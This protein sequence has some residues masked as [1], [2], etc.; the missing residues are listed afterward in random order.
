MRLR[1]W[2]YG[3]ARLCSPV[4]DWR[5]A[6][7]P[8]IA[9]IGAWLS[10]AIVID[11]DTA[12]AATAAAGSPEQTL[13]S[14]G[15]KLTFD[16][17]E[18][19]IEGNTV[20][21][22]IAIER[23]VYPYLGP[24]RSAESVEDARRAL[25]RAYQT[26]GYLTV[27]VDVPE[28][29]VKDGVV[30]LRVTE[31]RVEQLRVSDNRYYSR[32]EIRAS[33]PG[34]APGVV[35]NFPQV[36]KQLAALSTSPDRKITPVLK[37]GTETGTVDVDLKVE[38]KLPLHGGVELNNRQSPN[39]TP[40]RF[41]ANLRYD[42]LWQ[43]GHGIGATVQT[44]PQEPSK[45]QVFAATYV[46]PVSENLTLV[47][48]GVYSNSDVAAI[49]GTDV[50][51]NGTIWGIR[52][53]MPLPAKDASSQSV[54]LGFD[55]KDFKDSV[56][57]EGADSIET[58]I[59][60]G[61][62]SAQYRATF[63][64]GTRKHDASV[65]LNF[66]PRG[67]FGNNDSEFDDKRF[68]ATASFAY[69]RGDWKTEQPLSAGFALLGRLQ[70]QVSSGPLISNE[71]FTAGG[72]D[73]VRGYLE[74]EELGDN[75]VVAGLELRGPRLLYAQA[76]QDF[77]PFA[78]VEGGVLHILQPLPGQTSKFSLSSAGLGLRLRAYGGF[79]AAIDVALPFENGPV[80]QAGHARVNFMVAYEF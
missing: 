62:L 18:Y 23:A 75:G 8:A 9:V 36:Q 13:S 79:N 45:L 14:T 80:T 77:F 78:F 41:V 67:V 64:E 42:N 63:P 38:D 35:P 73:S 61:L 57:V 33:V 4:T 58:P 20:L 39:T 3:V 68:Q 26:A 15:G 52:A 72:V 56:H 12:L 1:Q 55:Y 27:V 22:P 24:N 2:H 74:A 28:Q 31:G 16:I 65:S 21:P 54:S 47:G 30:R 19:E 17:L 50:V 34:L 10:L 76:I 11:V 70:F 69:L 29:Q 37:P 46:A 51:G 71:Q 44:A 40:L 43:E 59:T 60:Y 25:E 7:P 53:I 32:S 49:G 48:Y 5:G 6:T 66:A